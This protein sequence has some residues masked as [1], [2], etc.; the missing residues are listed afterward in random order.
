M[1]AG[2][3]HPSLFDSGELGSDLALIQSVFKTLGTPTDESWPEARNFSDWGKMVFYEYPA[4]S[5]EEVLPEASEEGR[6]LVRRLVTYESGARMT[7][8]EVCVL[9]SKVY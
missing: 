7:A 8:A 4:K 6:D 9:R 1:V 2:R 5:W 3:P